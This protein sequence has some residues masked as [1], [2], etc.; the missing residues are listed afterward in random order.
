VQIQLI[1]CAAITSNRR[2]RC[3]FANAKNA[4]ISG[5]WLNPRGDGIEV[6]PRR[7]AV[8]GRRQIRAAVSSGIAAPVNGITLA[9]L[10]LDR[11][12]CVSIPAKL[13]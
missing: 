9:I 3:E 2:R 13:G 10:S 7:L 1:Q 5:A 11:Y 6:Q 12:R 8:A 4:Q